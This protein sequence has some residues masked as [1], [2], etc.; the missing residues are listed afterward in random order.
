MIKS[1]YQI[2]EISTQADFVEVKKAYRRLALRYHPDKNP[3]NKNA[4]TRFKEL[5]EA[6]QVLSSQEERKK[7]DEHLQAL[8]NS[9]STSDL[10]NTHQSHKESPGNSTFSGFDWNKQSFSARDIFNDVFGDFFFSKSSSNPNKAADLKYNLMLTLEE[11]HSGIEKQIHFIRKKNQHEEEVKLAIQIPPGIKNQQKLKLRG[12]GDQQDS[13]SPGD[14]YVV[15][16]VKRHPLFVVD[17][18]N[19]KQNLPISIVTALLGGESEILTLTGTLSLKIPPGTHSDQI[20]RIKSKGL[21][22]PSQQRGDL[23]VQII[24]DYP[25]Q[26]TPEDVKCLNSLKATAES[27]PLILGYKK[28]KNEWIN[29]QR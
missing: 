3:G 5:T 22:G 28:T 8:H 14:L 23:L 11:A 9:T 19:I 1:Y 13:L 20:F 29:K 27:S 4:E 6:Y 10:K 7:Y 16:H 25:R 24:V 18:L 21:T 15:V 2:L 26:W 17:G 12:E